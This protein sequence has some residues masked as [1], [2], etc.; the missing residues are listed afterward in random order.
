MSALLSHLIEK[1][2]DFPTILIVGGAGFIGSSL[3]QSLLSKKVNIFCVDN[4][5]TGNKENI[6]DLLNKPHFIFQEADINLPQVLEKIKPDYIFHLAGVE[7]YI[8]GLDVS[9]DTLLVNS[10]GTKNILDLAKKTNAKLLFVSSLSVY[11]GNMGSLSLAQDF[12]L[13]ESQ[14]QKY[15]HHEAKRFGEAL[16]AEYFRKYNL[17]IRIVRLRDCYGPKMP[18][19]EGSVISSFIKNAVN[20]HRIQ[21]KGDGLDVLN[22]V[23]IS[24]IVDGLEKAIFSPNTEGKIFTLANEKSISLVN[25]AYTLQKISPEKIEIEFIAGTSD[26]KVLKKTPEIK[27]TKELLRWEPKVD[28]EKGLFQTLKYFLQPP[29]I[30]APIEVISPI[31]NIKIES[32]PPGEKLLKKKK[33]KKSLILA[34]LLLIFIFV[35]LPLFITVGQIILGLNNL[36][37][38]KQNL[39][40]ADY[41][42]GLS[43][44]SLAKSNFAIAKSSLNSL[45]WFFTIFKQR[46]FSSSLNEKI[47]IMETAS[48]LATHLSLFAQTA[49]SLKEDLNL[50]F[51]PNIKEKTS[52]ASTE[53]KLINSELALIQALNQ[54]QKNICPI[55]I[56][57]CTSFE[58]IFLEI[59]RFRD[60]LFKIAKIIDNLPELLGSGSM[61][62]YLVL[63]QNNTE[64][65][66]TGGF[67]GSLALISFENGKLTETKIDNVYTYDGQLLGKVNPPDEILHY[68]GQPNWFLRDSN[69]SP[70]FP[71]TAKRVAWFFEKETGQQV[72]G[73]V[74]I[75]ISFV[76]N[77]LSVVGKIDLPDYQKIITA[78][79]LFAET[80][81]EAE[82]NHF[83]GSTQK[84]DFLSSLGKNLLLKLT[85]GK[86]DYLSLFFK[87]DQS[88]KEK[89]LQI[90]SF[91]NNLNILFEDLGI[92]GKMENDSC[93]PAD[94]CVKST[95]ALV[96]NNYGANKAN[97][98][99]KRNIKRTTLIYKEGEIR[100]KIVI[101]YQNNSPTD[102]WP[103]GNYKNYL[104][105]YVPL[106]SKFISLDL[107]D[108]KKATVSAVLTAQTLKDL[109]KDEFLVYESSESGKT[110]WGVLVNVPIK[111]EK[112]VE[113]FYELPQKINFISKNPILK[114]YQEKQSGTEKDSFEL[115]VG[116]PAFLKVNS[117][118]NQETSGVLVKPQIISYNTDLSVSRSLNINFSR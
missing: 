98:F 83:P 23:Y 94:S 43:R 3:C 71:L 85:D 92:S 49:N 114:I 102:T 51:P 112:K 62:K 26:F 57:I 10:Y 109:P 90:S 84:K 38:V 110:V 29:P 1:N 31:P 81:K 89:H 73:V 111:K 78:D 7:E 42:T 67:I 47:E 22:P 16:V 82:I 76:K 96:E 105:F 91:D 53:L 9:L 32:P 113:L 60:S 36:N 27:K 6:K 65:R 18:L 74:A 48:S 33:I 39:L 104:K 68:L 19:E 66:G 37:S 107:E 28:I 46:K 52:K 99:L 11:E 108:N 95:L 34:S 12:G 103:G 79:N 86:V 4:L 8:N 87:L 61:K 2:N 116:Y 50:G 58:N 14:I 59:P 55:K 5:S 117:V 35:F 88:A 20:N 30:T 44:S 63:F 75:D 101:N 41:Q 25:L 97:Y 118:N 64:I 80:E 21:I 54:D 45:S 17:D 106:G 70:D 93:L 69:I 13:S 24:D 115:A 72:D 100:E 77:I 56:G 15:T 40:K